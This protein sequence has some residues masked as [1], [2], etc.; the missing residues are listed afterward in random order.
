[1][2]NRL[3]NRKSLARV[4]ATPGKT[5]TINFFRVDNCRFVDLPGYGYAKVSKSEKERWA[6]L[7]DGY[8]TQDRNI[9]LVIQLVDM[10]HGPTQDDQDMIDFLLEMGLPFAVALTKADKLNQTETVQQETYYRDLF[11]EAQIPV[12]P[13]SSVKGTGITELLNQI[14]KAINPTERI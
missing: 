8:F 6:R 9:A 12:F 4:S 1:M 11:A 14:E 7:V 2:I 3:L 5:G 13:V 10:R